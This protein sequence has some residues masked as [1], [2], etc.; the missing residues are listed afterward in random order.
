MA[1]AELR[2]AATNLVANSQ[3]GLDSPEASTYAFLVHG[4]SGSV[5]VAEWDPL[6][7]Q[8]GEISDTELSRDLF[9]WIGDIALI[10][11]IETDKEEVTELGFMV[12]DELR[13]VEQLR[14]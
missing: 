8:N 5:Y 7:S 3:S 14:G 11:G 10:C 13:Y 9:E 4:Y 6:V 2:Q 1:E 12:M